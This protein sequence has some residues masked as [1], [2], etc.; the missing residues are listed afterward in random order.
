MK[1]IE[2]KICSTSY[3]LPQNKS[4]DKVSKMSKLTFSEYSDWIGFFSDSNE[5]Q[6]LFSILFFHDL[7]DKI[8]NKSQ[9]KKFFNFYFKLLT[10]R[11]RKRGSKVFICV[12]SFINPNILDFNKNSNINNFTYLNFLKRIS[13]IQSVYNNL[14]LVELDNIFGK[15]GYD[16]IF[17]YRNWYF[18]HCRLSSSGLEEL[19]CLVTRLIRKILNTPKKLLILD[20]DNTLWGGVIGEDGIKSISVGEDGV[21]K[22]YYNFQK[23]IKKLS[24]NGVLLAMA[25]KNNESDVLDVFKKKI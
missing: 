9:E 11:L 10:D 2:I 14:V 24:K 4:W 20:C 15:K 23:E 25:S 22:I 16:N 19:S 13:K 12:S 3:L 1:K 8:S 18:A 6:N 17:D 21:G 7:Y 5:N